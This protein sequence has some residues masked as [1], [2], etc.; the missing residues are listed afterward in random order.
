MP[1]RLAYQKMSKETLALLPTAPGNVERQIQ[2]DSAWWAKNI[3]AVSQAL[4]DLPRLTSG[5]GARGP[6]GAQ[7][8]RAAGRTRR[9]RGSAR[10]ALWP[11]LPLLA[12]L[13]VVFVGPIARVLLWGSCRRRLACRAHRGAVAGDPGDAALP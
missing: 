5:A 4:A 10:R 6:R 1:N 2:I 12:F 7:A 8:R 13:A 11:V 9:G 3:D